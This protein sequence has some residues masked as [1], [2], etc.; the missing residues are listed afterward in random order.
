[1]AFHKETKKQKEQERDMILMQH[2]TRK[3][4]SPNLTRPSSLKQVISPIK[5]ELTGFLQRAS[6]PPRQ[7]PNSPQKILNFL[8]NPAG[9]LGLQY[10]SNT[11]NHLL[12]YPGGLRSNTSSSRKG[13]PKTRE[14]NWHQVEGGEGRGSYFDK[15]EVYEESNYEDNTHH[16]QHGGNDSCKNL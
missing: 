9:G 2:K 14:Q 7:R 12:K 6:S 15:H 10:K 13:S 8:S 16:K 11:T 4:H 3:S 5:Q 1:M